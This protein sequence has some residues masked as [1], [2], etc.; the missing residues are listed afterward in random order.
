MKHY[1]D[2]VKECDKSLNLNPAYIKA[3]KKKSAASI[4]MLKFEDAL[5]A[6]KQAYAVEKTQ[7]TSNEI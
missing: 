6:L 5:N 4:Q 7:G 1:V 3:L 2:C